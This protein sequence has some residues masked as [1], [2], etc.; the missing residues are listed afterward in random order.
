MNFLYFKAGSIAKVVTKQDVRELGLE[1]ALGDSIE[2]REVL[3][4]PG[5]QRG[6]V[7]CDSARAGDRSA[8]YFPDQQTWREMPT[9]DGRPPLWIGYW[10]D[11]PPTPESLARAS[12]LPGVP[13]LMAD[14]RHW[15]IPIVR[16]YDEQRDVY[17]SNLP[18]YLDYDGEGRIVPGQ[19][20]A[21]HQR[22]WDLTAPVADAQFGTGDPLESEQQLYTAVVALLTANYVVDLPELVVLGVLASDYSLATVVEVSCRYDRLKKWIA[23]SE[24][25]KKTESTPT[26]PGSSTSAG[27]EA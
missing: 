20:L 6:V 19:V 12:Q 24:E 15:L 3:S 11:A 13:V 9:R 27:D 14:E 18:A 8:G 26:E 1:Y 5:G 23:E 7:F 21:C 17:T 4:G 25:Q 2:N 10:N 16:N 22:L